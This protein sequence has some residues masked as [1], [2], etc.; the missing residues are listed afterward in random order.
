[1][2][3]NQPTG[4]RSAASRRQDA[5]GD[6]RLPG[7]GVPLIQECREGRLHLRLESGIFEMLREDGSAADPGE[8]AELVVTSF[9]QW[10]TPLI[11]YATGDS[12]RSADSDEPCPC[13]RK[14]PYVHRV[15]GRVEDLVVTPDGRRIGMFS[16]RT[17]KHARG[18]AEAQIVQRTPTA[19]TVRYVPAGADPERLA[20]ELA[21]LFRAVLGYEPEVVVEPVQRLER[22]ANGK[23]RT[24]VRVFDA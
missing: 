19:F 16:Y 8:I 14:L 1:M 20:G 12:V 15:L 6:Q 7:E 11:R 5:S 13:G 22:G 10:K 2:R 21:E 4:V 17:V 9:V 18:I 3:G 24:V 23:L